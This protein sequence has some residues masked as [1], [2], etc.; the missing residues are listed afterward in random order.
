M[1]ASPLNKVWASH[2]SIPLI[3]RF[4]FG[5][6]RVHIDLCHSQSDAYAVMANVH[7]SSLDANTTIILIAQGPAQ[8]GDDPYKRNALEAYIQALR[9]DPELWRDVM[10]EL[11]SGLRQQLNQLPDALRRPRLT[12]HVMQRDFQDLRTDRPLPTGGRAVAMSIDEFTRLLF[13]DL[14]DA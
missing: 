11:I 14:V 6:S 13:R 10:R 9:A 7:Q 1:N 3:W 8:G 2:I 4:R 5:A 12:V